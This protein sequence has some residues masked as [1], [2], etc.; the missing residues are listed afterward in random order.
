MYSGSGGPGMLDTVRLKVR[1]LAI[2]RETTRWTGV[3]TKPSER[4]TSSAPSGFP[5]R[6]RSLVAAWI[7][8]SRRTGSGS[9]QGRST[10]MNEI[11]LPS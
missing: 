1:G 8:R 5:A 2:S 11:R 6:L 3:G 4:T 9:S 7:S 10:N